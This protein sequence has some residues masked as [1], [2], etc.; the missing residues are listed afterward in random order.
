MG[1]SQDGPTM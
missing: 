1:D